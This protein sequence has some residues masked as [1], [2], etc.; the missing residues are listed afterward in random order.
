MLLIIEWLLILIQWIGL[1]FNTTLSNLP[2]ELLFKTFASCTLHYSWYR[3]Y[4]FI[5]PSTVSNFEF[6]YKHS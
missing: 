5:N 4:L 6:K 3:T 1:S 2:S